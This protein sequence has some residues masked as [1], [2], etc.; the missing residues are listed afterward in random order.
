MASISH[1]GVTMKR[2]IIIVGLLAILSS[3]GTTGAPGTR[4][5]WIALETSATYARP[6]EFLPE[7]EP[8]SLRIPLFSIQPSA[9]DAKT[10]NVVEGGNSL[11]Q[12]FGVDLGN[13]LAIDA[14]GSV[15][16]DVLKLLRIDTNGTFSVTCRSA[17]ALGK[18]T[19]LKSDENG[20][21]LNW[22]RG[23]GTVVRSDS[24]L[25]LKEASGKEA[26]KIT[27]AGGVH[28]YKSS[29][30]FDPNYEMTAAEGRLTI[31]GGSLSG[32]LRIS[33]QGDS[34]IYNEAGD[35]T[36]P[37][38]TVSARG[39]AYFIETRTES[40]AYLFKVYFTDGTVYLVR[41]GFVILTVKTTG[42]SILVNG[43][44]VVTY[45]RG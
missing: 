31:K 19:T 37:K 15:F 4:P 24:G 40:A 11:L 12:P 36:R 13:G 6:M 45:S 7:I 41:N 27:A 28:T 30:M 22:P 38:Y 1:Y 3:C 42:S 2:G 8:V 25:V 44:E 10:V 20:M 26:M 9:F 23:N 35:P 33:R 18:S 39:D 17:F 5:D 21:T 34:V 29:I 14:G 32:V 43:K 16:L